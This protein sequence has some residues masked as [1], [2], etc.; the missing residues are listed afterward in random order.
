V[1]PLHPFPARSP[2]ARLRQ[3]AI[4]MIALALCALVA[5]SGTA[6][7]QGRVHR[8]LAH[9]HAPFSHPPT[10]IAN[11][12]SVIPLGNLNPGGGHVLAVNHM[13]LSYPVPQS[14]GAYAYP[15][16]AMGVGAV[17]MITR[18]QTEGRPDPD[19]ELFIAHGRQLTSY[20]IHIHV[21]SSRLQAYVAAVPDAAWIVAGSAG[22]VLLPGQLGA[23]PPLP[24]AA[25]EQLGVTKS[26]SS[27]WDV[28]VINAGVATVFEGHGPRRYPAIGDYLQL[29]GVAAAPPYAGQQTVNA[30]C[31]I[32][33]LREDLRGAWS[34]LLDST[35]R[36]GGRAGW[37]VAGRLRGA[38]FNPAL[39]TA[40]P[41]PL[42]EIESAA[43]SIIPDNH[44]PTTR[45]QIGIGAG[46]PL[47][48]L[49]PTGAYPQL[50]SPLVVTVNGAPGARVNPNPALV[51][52]D[53]GTV[54][55]DLAYGSF[56]GSRHN[57]ILFHM[58]DARTVA[59][60]LDPTPYGAPQ[61]AVIP[62]AEPDATWTTY[63]R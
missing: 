22:R 34:A 17:V 56:A 15:V 63:I 10:D 25:G 19:W 11:V 42:F 12:A 23:P 60:K 53:T 29:L 46:R 28:G 50:R 36:G 1:R 27:N 45:I 58:V 21:L 57:T 2:G 13:Y 32:D 62:L 43:L 54:C 59:I 38:W 41:A 8:S 5:G 30:V 14:N 9:S 31:F 33:Y 37:D 26:Y 48:A 20:F 52:P 7:G 6:T 35:P 61:C 49:D 47:S 39:D 44:A 16:Y 40:S 51:S 3:A 18:D 4:G 24:V 55:Y